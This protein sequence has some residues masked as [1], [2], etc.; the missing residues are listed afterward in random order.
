V[1]I[2]FIIKKGKNMQKTKMVEVSQ[3]L[4]PVLPKKPTQ[5]Q[6]ID[7]LLKAFVELNNRVITIERNMVTETSQANFAREVNILKSQFAAVS[8]VVFQ[9]ANEL[10]VETSVGKDVGVIATSG[11]SKIESY[12]KALRI[13]LEAGRV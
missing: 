13:L 5:K 3:S 1:E 6:Q 9:M 7:K 4:K 8:D 10:N 2:A 12:V 11:D